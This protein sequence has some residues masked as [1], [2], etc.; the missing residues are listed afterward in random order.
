LIEEEQTVSLQA[1]QVESDNFIEVDYWK[2][3]EILNVRSANIFPPNYNFRKVCS[4]DECSAVIDELNDFSE[5][6]RSL[7]EGI[8]DIT[9]FISHTVDHCF[10]LSLACDWSA[11]TLHKFRILLKEE[12]E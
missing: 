7:L 1:V 6:T 2:P 3:H 10:Y 8:M 12:N 4:C 9:S 5:S 11:R